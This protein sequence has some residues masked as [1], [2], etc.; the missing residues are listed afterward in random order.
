M[1]LVLLPFIQGCN[2]GGGSTPSATPTVAPQASV[3]AAPPAKADAPDTQADQALPPSHPPVDASA[4]AP[5]PNNPLEAL[6]ALKMRVDQ[7]PQDLQALISFAN[8][9]MMVERYQ[10]A[11]ELYTRALAINPKDL[12]VRTNLAIAYK[13]VPK[14]DQAIVELKKN[15]ETDPQH[16]A[17]LY[18]LGFIYAFDKR[19]FKAAAELWKKWLALY[20]NAEGA[21][22]VKEYLVQMESLPA[23]PPDASASGP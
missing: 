16:N 9:N 15:L 12:D 23:S 21:E 3:N 4:T 18:N 22:Q 11:A 8:A 13:Y 6:R 14:V 19:D 17:S 5:L 2:K 7:N 1:L 20:P 10:A